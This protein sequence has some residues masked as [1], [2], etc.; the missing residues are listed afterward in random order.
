MRA[1]ESKQ[2][3]NGKKLRTVANQT[4]GELDSWW[5]GLASL[6]PPKSIWISP[7]P[8]VCF[9]LPASKQMERPKQPN[10]A[11]LASTTT[12]TDAE[13]VEGAETAA[14]DPEIVDL[15]DS[16][17]GAAQP[18]QSE[19][20]FKP[21]RFF[22]KTETCK[23]GTETLSQALT[24]LLQGSWTSMREPQGL[25]KVRKPGNEEKSAI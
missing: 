23:D 21:A 14:K 25:V 10:T 19:G 2:V 12:R 16:D 9:L 17:E 22:G 6:L 20:G 18:A 13:E 7:F 4:R 5:C 3:A 15:V 24:R 1:R 8:A 11:M